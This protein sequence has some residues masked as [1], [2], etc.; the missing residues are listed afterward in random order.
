MYRI[1]LMPF[2]QIP[3]GHHHVAD[4]I[5][6]QLKKSSDTIHCEKLEILSYT[7]GK[8]EPFISSFYLQWIHQFP[9]LYSKV[10]KT[11]VNKRKDDRRY[12]LYELLFIRKLKN[13]MTEMKPNV[14][15]CTHALPSYLLNKLKKDGRWSGKLINVYTDY[16]INDLW[17]TSS[18]DYHFVPSFHSKQELME[19]GI[20][21]EQIFVTGIP[22]DPIFKMERNPREKFEKRQ[23]LIS[24]G[25]MGVGSIQRLVNKLNPSGAIIYYVLCGKNEG[26]LKQLVQLNHPFIKAVPYLESKSEM[27]QLYDQADAIITKPG[28]V[29]ITECL[30]KKLPIFVYEVLPGQEEFNFNYLF[31]QGL[32]VH[33]DDWDMSNDIEKI[34]LQKLDDGLPRVHKQL[35]VFSETLDKEEPAKIIEKICRGIV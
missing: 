3:S 25:N 35:E 16:Y 34:I 20:D 23:I 15:I 7:Y 27:N 11:T 24:G 2:L 12:H 8:V 5:Q 6:N 4:C 17:G 10:Y 29:T 13:V 18:V 1:L 30:W 26:L 33:L 9:N 28:G 19:R 32:I 31:H 21:A 22:V 14:V